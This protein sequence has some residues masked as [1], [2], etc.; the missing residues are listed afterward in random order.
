MILRLPLATFIQVLTS[1]S[2]LDL[3]TLFVLF[4][5][6][7][8]MLNVILTFVWMSLFLPLFFFSFL[9]VVFPLPHFSSVKTYNK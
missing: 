6:I 5:K 8:T 4:L 9:L 3:W 7:R 1:T 2:V